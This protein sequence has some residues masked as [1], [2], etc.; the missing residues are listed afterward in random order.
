[1]ET[2]RFRISQGEW[3]CATCGAPM[4]EDT[5]GDGVVMVHKDG[6]GQV[7]ALRRGQQ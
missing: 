5:S 2:W 1:M 7:A 4:A 3:V 6:C